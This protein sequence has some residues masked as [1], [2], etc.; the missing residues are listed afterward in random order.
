ML[1]SKIEKDSVKE[2]TKHGWLSY[3]FLSQLNKGL[4]DRVFIKSGNTVYIEYKQ[5]GKLP[6]KLQEKVH[7]DF[8]AHG[9]TVHVCHSVDET[10]EVLNAIA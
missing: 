8:L 6:T 1:E 10:M 4:P 2:A 9:V 3:K 5:M 7:R